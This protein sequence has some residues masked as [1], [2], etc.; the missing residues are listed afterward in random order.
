MAFGSRMSSLLEIQNGHFWRYNSGHTRVE[1]IAANELYQKDKDEK[2]AKPWV[3][4][5]K[6]LLTK[7]PLQV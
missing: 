5:V 3:K 1:S 4:P 6:I 2:V 7:T